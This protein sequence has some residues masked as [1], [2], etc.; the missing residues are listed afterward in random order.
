MD[1][2]L[3]DSGVGKIMLVI[4]IITLATVWMERKSNMKKIVEKLSSKSIIGKMYV[5][6]MARLCISIVRNYAVTGYIS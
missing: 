2:Q 6:S 5:K 4:G 3:Y 1:C